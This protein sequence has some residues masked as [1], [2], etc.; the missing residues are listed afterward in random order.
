MST[1]VELNFVLVVNRYLVVISFSPATNAGTK[2]C[3][4][5][6]QSST[7]WK[8]EAAVSVLGTIKTNLS[9]HRYWASTLIL[10]GLTGQ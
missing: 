1:G 10:G 7:F 6:R 4:K 2:Q 5:D 3:Y 8:L 9:V